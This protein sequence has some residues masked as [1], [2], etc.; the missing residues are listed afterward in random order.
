MKIVLFS[1]FPLDSSYNYTVNT[2][3][4]DKLVAQYYEMTQEALYNAIGAST[5]FNFIDRDSVHA[6]CTIDL[7]TVTKVVKGEK[8]PQIS[9]DYNYAIVYDNI[10]NRYKHYFITGWDFVSSKKIG[11]SFNNVYT[12]SFSLNL[13]AY[14]NVQETNSSL[15]NNILVDRTHI[16]DNVSKYSSEGQNIEP[17]YKEEYQIPIISDNLKN[18]SYTANKPLPMGRWY[19][20]ITNKQWG[21]NKNT[22]DFYGLSN[23]Y[24]YCVFDNLSSTSEKL[25]TS[26]FEKPGSLVKTNRQISTFSAVIQLLA[27]DKVQADS[28]VKIYVS[29]IPPISYLY[30]KKQ[31]NNHLTLHNTIDGDGNI[32]NTVSGTIVEIDTDIYTTLLTLSTYNTDSYG[33]IYLNRTQSKKTDYYPYTKLNI[34]SNDTHELQPEVQSIHLYTAL[35]PTKLGF[36]IVYSQTYIEGYNMYC[37]LL[38]CS[39]EIP[40]GSTAWNNY[41]ANNKNFYQ[42][43]VDIPRERADNATAGAL[44]NVVGGVVSGVGQIASGRLLTGA[45]GMADRA[46]SQLGNVVTSQLNAETTIKENQLQWDNIKNA[47]NKVKSLGTN[48][49]QFSRVGDIRLYYSRLNDTE[50]KTLETIFYR[51]GYKYGANVDTFEKLFVCTYFNY[52]KLGEPLFARYYGENLTDIQRDLLNQI[53]QRGV[54]YFEPDWFINHGLDYPET[55][56]YKETA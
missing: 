32:S 21:D 47:P 45:G 11:E 10:N 20:I 28:I 51:S 17:Q 35:S 36:I 2:Y 49:G 50:I 18:D 3:N 14:F 40:Y 19:Y 38:D 55:N 31:E 16:W 29:M 9:T 37:E 53:V 4:W 25:Y 30:S 12:V 44:F 8:T 48:I 46:I 43:G 13:L 5:E 22:V 39:N 52:V 23:L 1:G 6:S 15:P 24:C 7:A 27:R 56:P 42:M 34:F 54:T 41:V 26:T 33:I